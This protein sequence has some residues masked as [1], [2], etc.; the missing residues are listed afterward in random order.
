[1]GVKGYGMKRRGGTGIGVY[2]MDIGQKQSRIDTEH[3]HFY[4]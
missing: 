4:F 1:M 2:R 3:M